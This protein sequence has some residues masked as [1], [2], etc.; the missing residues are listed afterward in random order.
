MRVPHALHLYIWEMLFS[1]ME[2]LTQD[3]LYISPAIWTHSLPI[4]STE[5]VS[6][7]SQ[8][9]SSPLITSFHY[10]APVQNSRRSLTPNTSWLIDYTELK[11]KM[12]VKFPEV[13][14]S[15]PKHL[16]LPGSVFEESHSVVLP[17][18]EVFGKEG[19]WRARAQPL[20]LIP[21][22]HSSARKKKEK[23]KKNPLKSSLN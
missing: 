3:W 13:F 9:Q 15:A 16:F 14:L 19:A 23:K 18:V 21:K 22:A 10:Q 8:S 6:V 1:K 4:T 2:G 12:W 7:S 5:P 20:L 11:W 17:S